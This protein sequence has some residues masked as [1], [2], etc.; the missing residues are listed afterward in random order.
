MK[1]YT[2]PNVYFVPTA[3]AL[4]DSLFNAGG[5]AAGRYRIR[6]NGVLFMRPDGEP[7]AFLVK[8]PGS[9]P[10]FVTATKSEPDGGRIRYMYGLCDWHAEALGVASLKYGE[11]HDRAYEVWEQAQEITAQKQAAKA[12]V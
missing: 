11:Q 4:T 2:A 9:S 7:F 12:A 1:L 3:S 6:K 10:W 5:T 8:N